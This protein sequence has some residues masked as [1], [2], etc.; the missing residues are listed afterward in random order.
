M[1]LPAIAC[2]ATLPA[3]A[4][5][6]PIFLVCLGHGMEVARVFVSFPEDRRSRLS[7]RAKNPKGKQE[8]FFNLFVQPKVDHECVVKGVGRER[9]CPRA[10]SRLFLPSLSP[11]GGARWI[12][13]MRGFYFVRPSETKRSRRNFCACITFLPLTTRPNSL[14]FIAADLPCWLERDNL[15]A[16]SVS[17]D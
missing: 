7:D 2:C 6:S 3:T 16:Y 13:V 9:T 12:E 11:S 10:G 1:V 8:F 17:G 15:P 4:P 14:F 5:C